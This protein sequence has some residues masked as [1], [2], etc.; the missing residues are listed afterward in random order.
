METM[1]LVERPNPQQINIAVARLEY[2]SYVDCK[3]FFNF[4]HNIVVLVFSPR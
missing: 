2:P 3:F 4:R 1:I